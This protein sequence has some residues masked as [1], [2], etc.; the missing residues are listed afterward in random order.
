MHFGLLIFRGDLDILD[1]VLRHNHAF[2]DEIY[3]LDGSEDAVMSSAIV[4][5]YENVVFY[6]TDSKLPPEYRH[7]P[8]DGVLR[9]FLL[10]EIQ[11][12]HSGEGWVTL[13]HSDEIFY[14]KDPRLVAEEADAKG[15]DGVVWKNIP[16][17]LHTSQEGS[18]QYD[19]QKSVIEQVVWAALPG[20][21]EV[22]QFKNK[23]GIAFSQNRHM[24]TAPDRINN[25]MRTEYPLRHYPY[26]DQIQ[27]VRNAKDRISRGW[28]NYGGWMA[29]SRSVFVDVL[30]KYS[31][32]KKIE[33]GKIIVNGAT[34]EML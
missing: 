3:V 26:R 21:P 16:F 22:R 5:K 27:M 11:A 33:P 15:F 4:R 28:Q 32:S 13:L 14:D 9:R 7:P 18:Y 20:W 8:R 24:C 10:S 17:F 12:R 29:T 31:S 23:A 34:G 25:F 30:P 19:Q 1:E 6:T 2:F